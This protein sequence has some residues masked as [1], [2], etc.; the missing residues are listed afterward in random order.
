MY[1][2]PALPETAVPEPIKIPPLLPD[3]VLPEP[4]KKDPLLPTLAVPV[5]N[6]N[7]PLTPVTPALTVWS[8][9]GPELVAEA[10]PDAM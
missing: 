4:T 2:L 5:L 6:T 7:M 10:Y 8:K 3:A 1:T 9:T